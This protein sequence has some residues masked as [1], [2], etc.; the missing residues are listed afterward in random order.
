LTPIG[1]V[2]AIIVGAGRGIPVM[3]LTATSKEPRPLVFTI[4]DI[5]G[6]NEEAFTV[7]ANSGWLTTNATVSLPGTVQVTVRVTDDRSECVLVENGAVRRRNGGCFVEM[8]VG[9]VVVGF[10]TCPSSIVHYLALDQEEALL[11]W[12]T[13][14]IPSTAVG[15]SVVVS[16]GRKRFPP[17]KFS[18]AYTTSPELHGAV[19]RC[20][21]N[22]TV[23]NGFQRLA[24]YIRHE[25]TLSSLTDYIVDD[26]RFDLRVRGKL[27]SPA[28][29]ALPCRPKIFVM[30]CGLARVC[31]PGASH[32]RLF[33]GYFSGYLCLWD[34]QQ[35]G[36]A[37]YPC[38]KAW[39]RSADAHS[40]H[41]VHCWD[42]VQQRSRLSP[43]ERQRDPC[44][45]SPG[46]LCRSRCVVKLCRTPA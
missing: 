33:R 38:A 25:Q 19:A 45:R 34:H 39:H 31:L 24:A 29:A 22:I 9:I 13:P 3:Q 28:G 35:P 20:E 41:L 27:Q 36:R 12:E 7:H 30:A 16:D 18:I 32:A 17:G 44:R 8:Q 11:D 43:G 2:G 6:A 5:V 1:T 4:V 10:F 15:L 14:T 40:A 21:F 46:N 37:F 23:I 42:P 26:S